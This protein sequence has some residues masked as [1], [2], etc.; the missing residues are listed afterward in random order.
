MPK[1]KDVHDPEAVSA[2]IEKLPQARAMLVEAIRQAILGTDTVIGEQIKWNA[3]AYFYNAEMKAFD[4]KEYKR[5]IVVFNLRQKDHVLLIFPTGN[6][7][8]SDAGLLQGDY[9]DGRRMVKI[10]DI[11]D[12]HAKQQALLRAIKSWINLVEKP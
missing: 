4:A 1:S 8:A 3:P 9:A 10:F 12:L 5:D 11:I 7:I 2:Y 6:I